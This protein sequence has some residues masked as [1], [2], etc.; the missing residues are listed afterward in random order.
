MHKIHVSPELLLLINAAL[1]KDTE[2]PISVNHDALNWESVM[3]L[4]KWH[5]VRPLLFDYLGKNKN[6]EVPPKY[7]QILRDDTVSQTVTNM[8]FLKISLDFYK[9]LVAD[10][11]D[12]FLMKG[13]LWAWML[14]EKPGSREFGDIDYFI[15][16][17]S[18][19][20]SLKVLSR[21]G[22]EPDPYR[23]YLLKNKSVADLYLKTDY[24]LPLQPVK[25]NALQSL[26]IQWNSS[27]PRY[28]YSFTWDE[29]TA[30]MVDFHVLSDTIKIPCM[31]NQ[32]LMMVVHHAGIEQWDK[33]KYV[34]DFVRLL[35]LEAHRLNW[36]YITKTSQAK[37]FHRLVMEAL[38]V[39]REITGEDYLKYS[40]ALNQNIYPDKELMNNIVRHWENERPVLK[41]KSW[42]IFKYNFQYRDS[43]KD[44][45]NIIL[46]HLS[47]LTEW[48]LIW[49]KFVWYNKKRF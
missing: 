15:N 11:I 34:A 24:Q 8:T 18:I 28:C 47:Y 25:D 20:D 42:R 22:F 37:G 43:W 44:K 32:L 26:E 12:T 13:A 27:Y 19:Q 29:L 23:T 14:Y 2:L 10:G 4:A 30:G 39:V 35:R 1:K 21:N 41:T 38:G 31:E 7:S 3:K 45:M 17:Y 40:P 9:Q 6:I 36:N 5:Q 16:K 48:Q 49:H 46:A 33:L